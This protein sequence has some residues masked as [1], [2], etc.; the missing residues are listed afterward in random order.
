MGRLL[1]NAPP[2]KGPAWSTWLLHGRAPWLPSPPLA[3]LDVDPRAV[4]PVLA[5]QK[6][7]I[8]GQSSSLS[9]AVFTRRKLRRNGGQNG[10]SAGQCNADPAP[11]PKIVRHGRMGV[12]QNPQRGRMHLV[13]GVDLH[14]LVINHMRLVA[15]NQVEHVARHPF[16]PAWL[17]CWPLCPARP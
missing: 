15:H 3:M 2:E 1:P 5:C 13:Q 17:R 12:L 16:G 10:L 9:Q 14:V 6:P 4:F 8:P 11:G 7:V